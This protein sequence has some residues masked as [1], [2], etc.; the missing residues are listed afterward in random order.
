MIKF[1]SKEIY[2][3]VQSKPDSSKHS[4]DEFVNLGLSVAPDT[5]VVI[6]VSL[7][8]ETFLWRAKFEWP[9]EVVC[10]LEM[11]TSG[12]DFVDEVFD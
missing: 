11:G 1:V 4:V 3:A 5:T 7:F 2:L 8:S 12:G 9:E 6:W 10:F